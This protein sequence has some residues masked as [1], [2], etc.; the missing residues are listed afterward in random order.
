M[1]PRHPA[2]PVRVDGEGGWLLPGILPRGG[3]ADQRVVCV[4]PDGT[5]R[6]IERQ[7]IA[8]SKS[9]PATAGR[10]AHC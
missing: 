10:S 5:T 6:L 8:V 9:G 7:R 1:T 3:G 2:T 4:A